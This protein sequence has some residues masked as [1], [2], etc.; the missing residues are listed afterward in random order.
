MASDIKI[1]YNGTNYCLSGISKVSY[2]GGGVIGAT[3][4]STPFELSNNDV[5]GDIWTPITPPHTITYHGTGPFT[6]ER[7]RAYL[8]FDVKEEMMGIHVRAT[9]HDN[10]LILLRKLRIALTSGKAVLSVQPNGATNT[11]YWN[12]LYGDIQEQPQFITENEGTGFV[13]ATIRLILNARGAGA[14]LETIINAA[15]MINGP[16]GL[17]YNA[18]AFSTMSG[19]YVA[20]GQPCR[21]TLTGGDASG[22]GEKVLYLATIPTGRRA[23]YDSS[24]AIN[25]TNTTGVVVGAPTAATSWWGYGST[26]NLLNLRITGRVITPSTNLEV[27]VVVYYA[28]DVTGSIIY[29]SPWLGNTVSY[30]GTEARFYDFG[31][32]EITEDMLRMEQVRVDIIPYARSTNG[33]AA[34]G[35][36]DYIE[37]F[38]YQT[39]CKATVDPGTFA[40]DGIRIGDTNVTSVNNYCAKTPILCTYLAGTT[41]ESAAYGTIR[42]TAP[43]AF[44]GYDLY[45]S[46]TS[47]GKHDKTDSITVTAQQSP[48]YATLRGGG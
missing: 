43:K 41:A 9:T 36:W 34:T 32:I 42:G 18:K 46:W 47:A 26:E 3:P 6:S 38:T 27:R 16:G 8:G 25:T 20:I 5:T 24:T 40:H 48:Q 30:T 12:I 31:G 11:V 19:D 14:A 22:T 13:R 33:S 1:V 28:D 29:T 45:C 4:T 35:T 39:W 17:G 15:S 2:A 44:A 21:L 37:W 23:V 10:A 7:S